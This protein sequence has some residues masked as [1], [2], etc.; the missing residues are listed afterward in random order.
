M[1]TLTP[2]QARDFTINTS[3]APRDIDTVSKTVI[4][5]LAGFGMEKMN[6]VKLTY[7]FQATTPD[8]QQSR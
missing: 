7:S 1:G 5:D 2:G 4:V 8:I 6:T 3:L